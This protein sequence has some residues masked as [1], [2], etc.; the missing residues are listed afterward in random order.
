MPGLGGGGVLACGV[1][2]GG[3]GGGGVG[4][5]GGGTDPAGGSVLLMQCS[6]MGTDGATGTGNTC[7][8]GHVAIGPN[9]V[10]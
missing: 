5:P 9:I 4:S 3:A 8:P 2:A 6:F 10:L 1:L 7:T